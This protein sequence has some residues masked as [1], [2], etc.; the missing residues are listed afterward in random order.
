M[1][2]LFLIH[3]A[4]LLL[5]LIGSTPASANHILA[6]RFWWTTSSVGTVT[7]HASISLSCAEIAS[8]E[9]PGRWPE[10]GGNPAA[11]GQIYYSEDNCVSGSGSCALS[12]FEIHFG[13]ATQVSALH[14][15]VKEVGTIPCSGVCYAT[16][17]LVSG[18]AGNWTEGLPHSYNC[19]SATA[20]TAELLGH[21]RS[22]RTKINNRFSEFSTAGDAFTDPVR[23]RL[24]TQV[25]PCQ[26]T[27]NP[28]VF[29][30]TSGGQTEFPAIQFPENC[31]G[32]F[33]LNA[34]D[35][36]GGTITYSL[37]SP[38]GATSAPA[39]APGKSN[40]PPG[41]SVSSSGLITWC[42]DNPQVLHNGLPY[43]VQFYATDASGAN[44]VLDVLVIPC[45]DCPSTC[46]T[47]SGGVT[48][49]T[50]KYLGTATG[51]V[52]V[53]AGST[54][55]FGPQTISPN[56]NFVLNGSQ[57]DGRF[58]SNDL[59]LFVNGSQVGSIHVSC[60][61]VIS[62]GTTDESQGKGRNRFTNG[63]ADFEVVKAISRLGGEV[64]PTTTACSECKGGVTQLTLKYLDPSG[65]HNSTAA[66]LTVKAG[67]TTIFTTQ[68]LSGG[69]FTMNG[70]Q[71]DGKFAS[72]DLDFYVD[73]TA[74]SNKVGSLHVS[75]SDVITPGTTDRSQ[76]KGYT[77]TPEANADFE[78]VAAVSKDG[79]NVCPS[80]PPT[81]SC[82]DCEGGVTQLTL[83]YLGADNSNLIVKAGRTIIFDE[84]VDHN[85]TF[86]LVGSKKD[87]KFLKNDLDFFVNGSR[88]GSLHVSCSDV[89]SPGTT[90]E[91]QGKGHDR[92]SNGQADFE[93]VKAISKDGGEVCPPDP[94]G[95]CSECSGGVIRLTLKYLD[96]SGTHT[97]TAA[98]IV[99]KAGSTL[100]TTSPISVLSGGTFTLIGSQSDGR[101]ASNDLDFY[102]DGTASSNKVGSLHVSCSDVITPGTTDL[103][104]GKGYTRTPESHADFEVVEAYSRT[105]GK[106]CPSSGSIH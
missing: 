14:W 42:T 56:G 89:I 98:Q 99:V 74:S 92:Y 55:I 97:S 52:S 106:V 72:N 25:Q 4:A 64:C 80:T 93:V 79:G 36:N 17:E 7:F 22:Q 3:A 104:Q 19:S 83:K 13:D 95:S 23:F 62:P 85:E 31:C 94:G 53:K 26:T 60:S 65:T 37:V 58:S 20:Y 33:Q 54:T 87:G 16:M 67:S 81:S 11:V 9:V 1:R 69:T 90:D 21:W 47:C 101:F 2:R 73:G 12:E 15:R 63:Q 84:Q 35:V 28:P 50:L 48:Q 105:G 102:V 71:S 10:G 91:S 8:S 46:S 49:L 66:Q 29:Q 44:G 100:V 6:S 88:V 103:S 61:D 57:S 51:S 38:S 76:G 96:P 24:A 78:V 77:R 86:T 40:D 30:T 45:G 5:F 75:C 82:A 34:T 59:D 70:S 39:N 68:V 18:S 27:N 41:L 43:N 32:T